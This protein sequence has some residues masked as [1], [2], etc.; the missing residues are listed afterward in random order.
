V[1]A[2]ASDG[3]QAV[4]SIAEFDPSLA[5]SGII[6]ADKR[7]GQ[8][9]GEQKRPYRIVVPSDKRPARSLRMLA[10]IDVIQLAQ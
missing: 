3:Y 7:D 9:L 8:P 6:I 2:K 5:D 4:F 10:E 1:V